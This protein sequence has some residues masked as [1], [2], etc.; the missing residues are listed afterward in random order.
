MGRIVSTE[1]ID[2]AEVFELLAR[3]LP[4]GVLDSVFVAGS[5][6]AAYHHR[7]ELTERGVKTKDADLVLHPAD[8]HLAAAAIAQKLLDADWQPRHLPGL[9]PGDADTPADELP[10]IRLYPPDHQRYFVELLIVPSPEVRG[11]R[12]RPVNVGGAYYGLPMFEFM[13]LLARGRRRGGAIEYAAPAMMALANALSHPELDRLPPMS[14]PVGGRE[15]HRSSKDLGRVLALAWLAGPDE[16]DRWADEWL[17]ALRAVFTDRWH[18][19][20][21]GVGGGIRALCEDDERFD[22]AHHTCVVGL[23]G[24]KGVTQIALR[25]TARELVSL[26]LNRVEAEGAAKPPGE[27]T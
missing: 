19:L 24:G 15:I 1:V 26:V 21:S 11:K 17:D 8:N 7:D 27:A 10:A 16:L 23:L 5:L 25:A 6:A 18:S 2:P 20:A 22:E 4:D 12:W 9:G 14:T 13:A 3:E